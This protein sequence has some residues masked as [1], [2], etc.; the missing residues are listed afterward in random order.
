[1]AEG[2]TAEAGLVGSR[3]MVGVNAFMGG[4]ETNQTAYVCQVP[5]TAV[6][7]TAAPL[8]EE[9]DSVKQVRVVMLRYVQAYLAQLSQNVACN[10]LHTLEQRLARWLM[11][12]RDRL[13]SD[14]LGLTHEFIGQMLG[15]R[16]AGV[17]ET[18]GA[19]RERG[20]IE[21]GRKSIRVIDVGGVEAQ[22]CE[23]HAVVKDEYDRLL[24]R[25]AG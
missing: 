25:T 16:R 17:S 13:G 12:S 11:D 3:E 6:R 20:L 18:L 2:R 19:M 10:R 8:L 23:C 14:D 15:V 9:F 7:I 24:G 21:A 4:R 1:M 5:G 22:S